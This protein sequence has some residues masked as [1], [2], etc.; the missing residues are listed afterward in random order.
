MGTQVEKLEHNMVKLTVEVPADEF[1]KAMESAYR[2]MRNKITVP[3]FRKGKAPLQLVEKMY[4][5]E[6]FYEDAANECINASYPKAIEEAALDVVSR[7]DFDLT[8]IEKGKDLIYTATV[9]VK[10]EVKL[11]KY[12]GVE[13]TMQDI[14]V[15]DEEIDAEIKREQE[16][17]AR[18]I[19]V[20]DRAVENGD[21]VTFDYAGSIDGVAFEG[22]TAENQT[23][24]IGSGMFIPG[25][26]D[27]LVGVK[28]EEETEVK[29]TFPEE[30]H[31]E[32]LAGKDAVFVCKVHKIQKKELPAL[33]DE[34]A[35]DV[36]EFET[37]K[38]YREDV[39][40]NITKRKEETAKRMQEN[41]AV[42]KL[43]EVAEMD[44]PEAMVDYQTEQSYFNYAQQLQSQGI[45]IDM[46]M[47]YQGQDEE[48]FKAG[49]RPQALKQIQTRLSLEQLVK[50]ENIE[51]SDARIEEEIEKMAENYQIEKEK[52]LELMG[53]SEREELK[54]DLAVQEA[55][56]FL[57]ENAKQVKPK[58]EKKAAEE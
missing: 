44:I 2:G 28:L 50:E 8:Q 35:Q 1:T 30:Y 43:I 36:S 34:F 40:K 47:Q 22:G 37:I 21:T 57:V 15:T 46:Y 18:M 3:G 20:D 11:G 14:E 51:V 16:K 24:E 39:K 17:N 27:Q 53:E 23:L 29:V 45:P 33:D 31:A 52:M 49:L 12:K 10:P 41:E 48:S 54:K 5:P 32:N 9:A 26:E 4:G 38:E 55:I 7:A 42:D 25:F 6:I 56:T 58:K 13:I 19:D